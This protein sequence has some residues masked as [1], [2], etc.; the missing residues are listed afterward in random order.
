MARCQERERS[1]R[2]AAKYATVP[3]VKISQSYPRRDERW[4]MINQRAMAF[5]GTI[6]VL[7]LIGGEGDEQAERDQPDGEVAADHGRGGDQESEKEAP[8]RQPRTSE[9][10]VSS[11]SSQLRPSTWKT[12]STDLPK[13]R[14]SVIARGSDG[15]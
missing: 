8:G 6:I 7:T 12:S 3:P 2:A 5:A 10:R 1:Q 15:M 4:E 9:Y 11:V 14:A 13:K